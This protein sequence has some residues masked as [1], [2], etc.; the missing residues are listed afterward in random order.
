MPY[1]MIPAALGICFTL[2][3]A[4][5]GGMVVR[6]GQLAMRREREELRVGGVVSG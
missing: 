2:V 5:I 3:W 1:S 6:E 4:L